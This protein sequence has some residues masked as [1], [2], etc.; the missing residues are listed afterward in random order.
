MFGRIF[1]SEVA[2]FIA[3]PHFVNILRPTKFVERRILIAQFHIDEAVKHHWVRGKHTAR[4]LKY[5][6]PLTISYLLFDFYAARTNMLAVDEDISREC[7]WLKELRNR[8]KHLN[9]LVRPVVFNH[10]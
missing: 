10:L 9:A 1:K 3:Q 5:S 2:Q 6:V 4:E 7:A 8:H